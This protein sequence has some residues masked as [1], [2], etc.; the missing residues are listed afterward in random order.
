[1]EPLLVAGQIV[2]IEPCRPEDLRVGDLVAF[3]RESAVILHRVLRRDPRTGEVT[4]KGDNTPLPT[5]VGAD[6]VLGRAT[7]RLDP[8]RPFRSGPG[9]ARLSALHG[10]I[11]RS[12]GCIAT[13]YPRSQ[14]PVLLRLL[15]R[16]LH[17]V[18]RVVF[19]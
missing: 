7:Q 5:R 9:I 8:P 10:A 13:R 15:D 1:M 12:I 6:R 4:E 11:H 17:A 14:L 18:R 16:F 3:E 2:R 19:K